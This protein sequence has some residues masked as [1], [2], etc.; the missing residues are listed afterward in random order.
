V[1]EI[2]GAD[3]AKVHNPQSKA[4]DGG[5]WSGPSFSILSKSP[6][7]HNRQN[8]NSSCEMCQAGVIEHGFLFHEPKRQTYASVS[9]KAACAL[10]P[11]P[12]HSKT[13]AR[14]VVLLGTCVMAVI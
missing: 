5:V 1:R 2:S 3:R 8:Y 11:H 13:L 7:L 10:N 14:L 12:P 6:R 4:M 9:T